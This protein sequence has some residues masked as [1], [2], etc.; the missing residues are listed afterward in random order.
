MGVFMKIGLNK[1]IFFIIV[2]MM[3][4]SSDRVYG[5]KRNELAKPELLAGS[6]NGQ[7][8]YNLKKARVIQD[9]LPASV[10]KSFQD[11]PTGKIVHPLS[12]ENLIG[13]DLKQDKDAAH[14]EDITEEEE[15]NETEY[16]PSEAEIELLN[17]IKVLKAREECEGNNKRLRDILWRAVRDGQLLV[18]QQLIH[19]QPEISIIPR[20][21]ILL[22]DPAYNLLEAIKCRNEAV[23]ILIFNKLIPQAKNELFSRS[24]LF[25]LLCEGGLT[26]F[27]IRAL[28]R[29]PALLFDNNY[30]AFRRAVLFG[31]RDLCVL[32]MSKIP[33]DAEIYK[34]SEFFTDACT[35]GLLFVVQ[36]CLEQNPRIIKDSGRTSLRQAIINRRVGICDWLLEQGVE[37]NRSNRCLGFTMQDHEFIATVMQDRLDRSHEKVA[38]TTFGNLQAIH[39]IIGDYIGVTP[40]TISYNDQHGKTFC[41]NDAQATR[42]MACRHDEDLAEFTDACAEHTAWQAEQASKKRK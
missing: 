37:Y 40:K 16:V 34:D 15:N 22:G 19:F 10:A 30:W 11:V 24:D 3:T 41:V 33:S 12:L 1:N 21:G 5:I 27:V 36:R 2:C 29:K 20:Y 31:H 6:G 38:E 35:E 26:Q 39:D 4:M 9:V 42:E 14:K 32:L 25:V 18:V 28:E 8:Y 17:E 13:D 23:F 7:D